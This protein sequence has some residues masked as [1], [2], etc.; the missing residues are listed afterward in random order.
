MT[1]VPEELWGKGRASLPDAEHV[2]DVLCRGAMIA[3]AGK[4]LYRRRKNLARAALQPGRG[5]ARFAGGEV[6]H[7]GRTR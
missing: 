3:A 7:T 6:A 5:A 1:N 2:R 4:H